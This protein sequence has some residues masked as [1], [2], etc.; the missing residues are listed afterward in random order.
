MQCLD[1]DSEHAHTLMSVLL[2][3]TSLC[4]IISHNVFILLQACGLLVVLSVYML[5][6]ALWSCIASMLYNP[7][8]RLSNYPTNGNYMPTQWCTFLIA[9]NRLI[10]K[11]CT[12][13]NRLHDRHVY[14]LLATHVATCGYSVELMFGC[15]Y[16]RM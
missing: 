8:R 7:S 5:Q 3:D 9:S 14:D 16:I 10:A 13:P 1:S 4:F 12:V 2:L 15:T 6:H 11:S